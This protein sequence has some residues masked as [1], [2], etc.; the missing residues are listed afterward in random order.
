MPQ[1]TI[2]VEVEGFEGELGRIEITNARAEAGLG[3]D[4][5]LYC[6]AQVDADG[7]ARFVDWGYATIDEARAAWPDAAGV[8]G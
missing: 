4:D 1:S 6:V 5:R 3:R 2:I 8:A 7:I